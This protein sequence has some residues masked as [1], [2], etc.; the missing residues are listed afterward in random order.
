MHDPYF[1]HRLVP[2]AIP[3]LARLAGA[4]LSFALF[5]GVIVSTLVT[6]A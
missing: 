3:A 4:L 2:D 5:G 1:D 6:G